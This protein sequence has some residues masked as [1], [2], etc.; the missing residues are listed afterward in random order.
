MLNPEV[1]RERARR[2]WQKVER[3]IQTPPEA[4]L[5]CRPEHLLYFA[6][7]LPTTGTLNL[8]SSAFFLMRPDGTSTLFTD[9]WLG[10]PPRNAA[11]DVV[12]VDWYDMQSAARHRQRAV[13][14]TVIEHFQDVSLGVLGVEGEAVP[15][16]VASHCDQC[17]DLEP[18]ILTMREIKN[19]D[20]IEAIETA[21]AVAESLHRA[22][23]EFVE[24]GQREIDVLA[25]IVNHATRE[26]GHH[27]DMRSDI[28]S[29][30]RTLNLSGE[31]TQRVLGR[32]ELVILDLFPV[33]EGYRADIT[34]T[35]AVDRQPTAAQTEAFHV[36]EEALRAGEAE[37]RPG[38]PATA[39]FET[40]DR[41]LST[42][43]DNRS[44]VHHGGHAIGLGHPEAPHIV[45]N[46]NREL[47]SGMVIT[48]EPGLYDP[49]FGGIRLEHDYLVTDA[50]YRRLSSHV[51][52][53]A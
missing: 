10:P 7:T 15:A 50:G 35:L 8:E 11:D 40:M 3:E 20:E 31:P 30:D 21:I 34:N 36:V 17:I 47:A 18:L 22:S 28:L 4:I 33:V 44:L 38:I 39:V 1:C 29:G 5:V 52:G 53:L 45:R 51:L 43:G 32:G 26:T 19:A 27:F 49:S 9:N 42:S 24:P 6:N 13:T 41:V 48:L 12:V 16:V 25:Q 14:E 37:L 23:W 46:S 2:L